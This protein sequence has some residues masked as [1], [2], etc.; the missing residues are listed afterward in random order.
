MLCSSDQRSLY[1]WRHPNADNLSL[2]D[3]HELLLCEKR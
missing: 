1:I 3:G 2:R